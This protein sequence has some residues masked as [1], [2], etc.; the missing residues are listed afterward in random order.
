M[1]EKR[2]GMLGLDVMGQNLALNLAEK[3]FSVGGYDA[4]PEPVDRFVAAGAG[5]DIAGYKTLPAFVAARNS[6]IISV[7]ICITISL[8]LGVLLSRAGFRSFGSGFLGL[9][10]GSS[11]HLGKSR[12]AE[13]GIVF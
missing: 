1:S 2:V 11:I 6:L 13:Q 9:T 3:G 4:W 7:V 8:L 12:F 5:A 10:I